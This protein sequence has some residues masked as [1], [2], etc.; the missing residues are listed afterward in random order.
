MS[1]D[2]PW[3]WVQDRFLGLNPQGQDEAAN[4]AGA[5]GLLGGAVDQNPMGY[6]DRAQT[7]TPPAL[8]DPTVLRYSNG[9][10]VIDPNSKSPYPLPLGM[11]VTAN[12]DEA[13]NRSKDLPIA[14]DAWMLSQFFAGQPQDYQRPDGLLAA[15]RDGDIIGRN[16][17]VS[18]Y[19]F[20]VVARR[21]GYSLEDT[22]QAA[23]FYN[24]HFGNP[25]AGASKYGN[26]QSQVDVITQ[27]WN[28]GP[29]W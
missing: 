12:A 8:V 27:G 10:P 6:V 4:S 9:D 1:D 21:M 29:K 13:S 3:G 5:S 7:G 24:K 18:G 28:D 19:N 11:D 16:R 20:G 26:D 15:M 25:K 17:D 2:N 14:K 23:G 22:R